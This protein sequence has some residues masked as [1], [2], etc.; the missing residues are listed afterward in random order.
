MLD[1]SDSFADDGVTS[2]DAVAVS[3]SNV[4]DDTLLISDGAQQSRGQSAIVSHLFK[5]IF[6]MEVLVN[7]DGQRPVCI[8]L[9]ITGGALPAS[10]VRI[11]QEMD[12]SFGA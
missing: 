1:S 5:A 10:L 4:I 9:T 11:D 2:D 6:L 3:D 12:L 8:F 7:F